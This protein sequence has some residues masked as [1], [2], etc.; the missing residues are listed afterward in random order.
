MFRV[1]H[2]FKGIPIVEGLAVTVAICFSTTVLADFVA[3]DTFEAYAVDTDLNGQGGWSTGPQ[4]NFSAMVV[5][6]PEN[7]T[8][9]VLQANNTGG[10]GRV[11]NDYQAS[12]GGLNISTGT[13]GTVFTRFRSSAGGVDIAFGSS[14]IDQATLLAAAADGGRFDNFEAYGRIQNNGTEYQARDG[15]GFT[16]GSPLAIT[17]DTWYN[18]WLVLDNSATTYE[19]Y[20]QGPS[21]PNPVQYLAGGTGTFAFRTTGTP[22]GSIISYLIDSNATTPDTFYDDIYVDP[23]GENLTNPVTGI[24]IIPGDVDGDGDVDLVETD[25]DMISDFDIIR[26]HFQMEVTMRSEGDLT[27]DNFVGFADFRQWKAEFLAAGGS[28][29]GVDLS[30]LTVGVPEPSSICL[31]LLAICGLLPGTRRQR[32]D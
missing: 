17:T 2:M 26:D 10:T 30:F 3:V 15:G 28:L 5:L 31:I 7:A 20:I 24:E 14:D 4:T 22:H 16:T 1:T 29:E 27:F 23:D 18:L 21:D 11:F 8:N 13:T 32:S 25:M 19:T 6:D 12:R 9:R